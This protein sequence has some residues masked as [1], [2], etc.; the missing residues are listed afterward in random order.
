M[1]CTTLRVSLTQESMTTLT[2]GFIWRNCSKVCR[3]SMPGINRSSRTRSGLR[4]FSTC[5][6]ASSP[7]VAVWT[8]YSSTS[9]R[10]RMYRNIPGS[11]STRRILVSSLIF[12]SLTR[13]PRPGFQWY[14][15]GE[16][17]SGSDFTLDPNLSAQ[18]VYQAARDG[19]S[20]AH[21]VV[22]L[23]GLGYPKEVIEHFQVELGRNAR[24]S[25]R[26]A[27]LYGVRMG[28][29]LSSALFD[30]SWLRYAAALPHARFDMQ[31][32][33]SPSRRELGCVVH[34]IR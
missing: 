1:A 2:P 7:V 15:E 27:N 11:S 3:P 21:P 30:Y 20:K 19:E 10:V 12:F 32:H 26:D 14:K 22:W 29:V 8:L 9:S 18:G 13:C 24:A 17:A 16:L 33:G 28:H 6:R 5:L 31:P 34:Q 4:P 25:V 23:S